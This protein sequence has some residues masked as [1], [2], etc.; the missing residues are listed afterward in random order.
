MD[1]YAVERTI[2][3]TAPKPQKRDLRR[4]RSR[5]SKLGRRRSLVETCKLNAFE[6]HAYLTATLPA[7][8][9]GQKQRQ[10]DAL[11]PWNYARKM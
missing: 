8:V 9:N 2:R 11:V 3:T 4:S 7:I 6:P 1:S 5:R 10:I